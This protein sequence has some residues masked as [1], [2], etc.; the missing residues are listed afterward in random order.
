[1]TDER[2][3]AAA[4]KCRETYRRKAEARERA[5]AERRAQI[6]ALRRVRDDPDADPGDVLRAVEQLSKLAPIY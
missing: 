3:V 4:E 6:A 5:K 1:M 2:R